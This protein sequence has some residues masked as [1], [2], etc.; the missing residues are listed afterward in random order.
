MPTIQLNRT[1][2]KAK[3][4]TYLNNPLEHPIIKDGFL[5]DY[6]CGAYFFAFGNA[7]L[8]RFNLWLSALPRS[9]KFKGSVS[10]EIKRGDLYYVWYYNN[11]DY[12]ESLYTRWYS[13]TLSLPSD[14]KLDESSLLSWIIGKGSLHNDGESIKLCVKRPISDDK[15]YN[16]LYLL[17]DSLLGPYAGLTWEPY[18]KYTSRYIIV[19]IDSLYQFYNSGLVITEDQL[20]YQK[21]FNNSLSMVFQ[22]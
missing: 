5:G 17:L 18:S 7:D 1:D 8:D 9:I 11:V 2:T 6:S 10:E 4:N 20:L 12:C 15:Q 14:F 21:T 22:K 16:K 13:P 19:P 3:S